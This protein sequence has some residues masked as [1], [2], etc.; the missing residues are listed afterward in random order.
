MLDSGD[1]ASA[2]THYVEGHLSSNY[3]RHKRAKFAYDIMRYGTDL[4]DLKELQSNES[5]GLNFAFELDPSCNDHPLFHGVSSPATIIKQATEYKSTYLDRPV[6]GPSFCAPKLHSWEKAA[7]REIPAPRLRYLAFANKIQLGHVAESARQF[8]FPE[9]DLLAPL[10]DAYF[11]N[12]NVI[13]PLLHEPLFRKSV[14]EGRH[15]K[16][17]GF[18]QILLLVCAIGS[19]WIAGKPNSDSTL[20]FQWYN[21]VRYSTRSQLAPPTLCDAQ[22]CYVSSLHLLVMKVLL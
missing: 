16:D 11:N 10:L 15:L 17:P 21:Q 6:R 8:S 22:Y 2:V 20:G 7:V 14:S 12:F 13:T 3:W 1:T 5:D 4:I 19:R 9:P 18:A